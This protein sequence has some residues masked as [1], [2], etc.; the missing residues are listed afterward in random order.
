MLRG[1]HVILAFLLELIDLV[2]ELSVR[3]EEVLEGLV[4]LLTRLLGLIR[5]ILLQELSTL[6]LWSRR[7]LALHF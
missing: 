2:V 6:G 4:I 5:Q 1:I 3:V 7:R